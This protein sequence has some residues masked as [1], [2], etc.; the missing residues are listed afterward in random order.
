LADAPY[1]ADLIAA[2]RAGTL[3][4]N[5]DTR[6]NP[7]Y[8]LVAGGVISTADDLATWMRELVGGKILDA[9]YQRRWLD[10]PEP[11][12]P[13]PGVFTGKARRTSLGAA[14]N[15]VLPRIGRAPALHLWR[16]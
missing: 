13:N 5:D 11:E 3:K 9:D 1:P 6:Q 7:S 12:D 10:S 14:R 4:P 8:A 16:P 2:A 15:R